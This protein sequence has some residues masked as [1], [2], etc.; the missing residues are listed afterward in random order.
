MTPPRS[1]RSRQARPPRLRPEGYE[2]LRGV[3]SLVFSVGS[4]A[5]GRGRL[6]LYFESR[7]ATGGVIHRQRDIGIDAMRMSSQVR[8][9][10]GAVGHGNF[11]YF[12]YFEMT[13]AKFRNLSSPGG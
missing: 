8:A 1:G 5:P 9:R 4:S 10:E 6:C 13:K 2:G 3:G 12:E 11:E 7:V